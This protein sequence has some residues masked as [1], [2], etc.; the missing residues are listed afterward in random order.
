M[1]SVCITTRQ[2]EVPLKTTLAAIAPV[3]APQAARIGRT[4]RSAGWLRR[5]DLL[6]GAG[7]D[8]MLRELRQTYGYDRGSRH[9]PDGGRYLFRSDLSAD[10]RSPDMVR[11]H[12]PWSATDS[13]APGFVLS[14]PPDGRPV[15]HD[16]PIHIRFGTRAAPARVD[17]HTR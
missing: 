10:T 17:R 15:L 1:R 4:E 2:R 6:T 12:P 16:L 11:V 14:R 5:A 8:G 9:R 7:L 3:L 13:D